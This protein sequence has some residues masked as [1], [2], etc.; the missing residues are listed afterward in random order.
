[1]ELD[2]DNLNKAKL[3]K[4]DIMRLGAAA[5]PYAGGQRID[6]LRGYFR[7]YLEPFLRGL[8][9]KGYIKDF[10]IGISPVFFWQPRLRVYFEGNKYFEMP[11]NGFYPITRIVRV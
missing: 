3:I 2:T 1:M 6:A 5:E 9:A 10:R 7:Q 8:K 11:L 4:A